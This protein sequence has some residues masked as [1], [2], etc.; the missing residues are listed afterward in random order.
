M[1]K[2]PFNVLPKLKDQRGFTLI[3]LMICVLILTCLMTLAMF[4]FQD[5]RNRSAD[6]QALSEG[7]N[8]LTAASD[9]FLGNEDVLFTSG[10]PHAGAV[11]TLQSDA[12]TPRNAVYTLSSKIRARLTGQ[13]TPQLG[14][15]FLT[16]YIWSIEGSNDAFFGSGKKEYKFVIDEDQNIIDLPNNT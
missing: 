9:V 1:L 7:K 13:S 11:G 15:R 16:F 2:I 8:L 10:D 12:A 14:G 3:E 4:L 6:M 5:F